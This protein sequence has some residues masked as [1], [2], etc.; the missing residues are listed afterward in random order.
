[1]KK[2]FAGFVTISIMLVT[3]EAAHA[4]EI[5]NILNYQ[6]ANKNKCTQKLSCFLKKRK[7]C[8][9]PDIVA[10]EYALQNG[11]SFEKAK[12]ILY[13][14]YGTPEAKQ[15]DKYNIVHN[16]YGLV[17]EEQ[18]LLEAG[19]PLDLILTGNDDLIMN[20][21]IENNI[22]NYTQKI[23]INFDLVL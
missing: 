10:Y 20:F 15:G 9:N 5:H 16:P 19:V 3:L 13:K 7:D 6:K 8:N 22:S 1:M 21:I 11:I 23:R 12:I 18:Q 2:I 14:T 17:P 4:Y